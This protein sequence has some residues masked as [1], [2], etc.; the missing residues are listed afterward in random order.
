MW[1]ILFIIGWLLFWFSLFL[2]MNTSIGGLTDAG[3]PYFGFVNLFYSIVSILIVPE[4]I[5]LGILNPDEYLSGNNL[6]NFLGIFMTAGVGVCNLIMIF[7]PL[8]VWFNF[9]KNALVSS[10]M[11][12]CALYICTI[13]S[14]VSHHFYPIRYG[15]FV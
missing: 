8:I 11:I 15:H 5:I 13:G 2:P 4:E 9:K 10:I 6:S 7:S 1:K 3:K 14:I 12:V